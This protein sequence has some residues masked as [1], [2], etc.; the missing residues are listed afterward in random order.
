MMDYLGLQAGQ[1]Y[2][3]EAAQGDSSGVTNYISYQLN[4]KRCSA[5]MAC[6]MDQLNAELDK[7]NYA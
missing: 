5:S 3:V 1:C 6:M 4:I 7:H 2:S